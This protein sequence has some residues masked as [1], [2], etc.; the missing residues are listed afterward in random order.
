[1]VH[2]RIQVRKAAVVVETALRS[3]KQPTQR[4]RPVFVVGRT[5]GLEIVDANV[6]GRVQVVPRAMNSAANARAA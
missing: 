1:V 3:R 5:A 2:D 4:R 6:L